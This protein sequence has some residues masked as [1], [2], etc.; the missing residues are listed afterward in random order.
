MPIYARE[1]LS[2][3]NAAMTK[4]DKKKKEMKQM[5]G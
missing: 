4:E 5:V 1:E 2:L 3:I